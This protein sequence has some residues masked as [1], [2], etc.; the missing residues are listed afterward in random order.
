MAGRVIVTL[1]YT[2]TT[3]RGT[4]TLKR[5][6]PEKATTRRQNAERLPAPEQPEMPSPLSPLKILQHNASDNRFMQ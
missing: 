6:P 5:L 1:P 2:H 3:P 4:V